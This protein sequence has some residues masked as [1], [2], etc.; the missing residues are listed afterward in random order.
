MEK[1][2]CNVIIATPGRELENHYVRSL[3]ETVYELNRRNISNL[4][5]NDAYTIVNVAREL[6]LDGG[7]IMGKTEVDYTTKGPLRD[8][9]TYDKIFMIDSDMAWDVDQFLKL[10]YSDKD[11]ISGIYLDA[12]GKATTT[13]KDYSYYDKDLSE[14]DEIIEA[15]SF[16][17]GFVCVK[18]GVFESL[19]RPWFKFVNTDMYSPHPK[20]FMVGEDISWC[21]RLQELGYKT[22]CDLGVKVKHVKKVVLG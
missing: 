3:M 19:E 13:P 21:W 10:Y 5:L 9:V 2:H 16:G 11:I 1:P 15:Q 8:T 7:Y 12:R 22:Y 4:W 20:E 6:T 18:S 17:L 14:L